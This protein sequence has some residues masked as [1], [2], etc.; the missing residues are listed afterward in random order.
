MPNLIVIIGTITGFS[1]E[2]YEKAAAMIFTEE[3]MGG[4][5]GSLMHFVDSAS[6]AD[7]FVENTATKHLINNVHRFY[8]RDGAL[9]KDN[10]VAVPDDEGNP[11][12]DC[13]ESELARANCANS[14]EEILTDARTYLKR[15]GRI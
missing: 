7:A 15:T 5:H 11:I 14:V 2:A 1:T 12:V 9:L 6:E 3:V 13:W 10:V 4:G 8:V